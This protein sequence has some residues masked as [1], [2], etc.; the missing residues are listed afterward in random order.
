L[1]DTK[2]RQLLEGKKYQIAPDGKIGVWH[3]GNTKLGVVFII[4][5][6]QPYEMDFEQLLNAE[7]TVS[8]H[9]SGKATALQ[10]N[11]LLGET[12]VAKIAGILAE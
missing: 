7:N 4:K 5:F 1:A 3:D 9:F 6:E 10:I 8:Q 12:R 2:I 11:V